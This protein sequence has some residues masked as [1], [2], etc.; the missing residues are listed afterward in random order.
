M[1][2]VNNLWCISSFIILFIWLLPGRYVCLSIIDILVSEEDL[3]CAIFVLSLTICKSL[4]WMPWVFPGSD[5]PRNESVL[6]IYGNPKIQTLLLSPSS[7]SCS[8]VSWCQPFD[9]YG[10]EWMTSIVFGPLSSELLPSMSVQLIR[11]PH[12]HCL[13]IVVWVLFYWLEKLRVHK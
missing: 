6:W 5:P 10:Y 2:S 9:S 1:E 13:S 11:C 8:S 12:L 7:S 4:T 3:C